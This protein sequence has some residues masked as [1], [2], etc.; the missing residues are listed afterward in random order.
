MISESRGILKATSALDRETAPIRRLWIEASD[1]DYP[2]LSVL[3]PID[4]IVED[5]N[6]NDPEF[7]KVGVGRV[8]KNRSSVCALDAEV[9][10][11]FVWAHFAFELFANAF[12]LYIHGRISRKVEKIL[13]IL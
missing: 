11:E 6:D 2:P 8:Y 12:P 4:I 9:L 5:A 1:G 7:E 13:D 3:T 10:V